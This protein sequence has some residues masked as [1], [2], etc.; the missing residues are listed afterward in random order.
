M[1]KNIILATATITL[2]YSCSVY[3]PVPCSFNFE[4]IEYFDDI[5]RYDKVFENWETILFIFD[6]NSCFSFSSYCSYSINITFDILDAILNRLNK[7][8]FDIKIIIHNHFLV[9]SFSYADLWF[10]KRLWLRGFTGSFQLYF[11]STS[12]IVEII[13]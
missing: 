6:D 4:A 9:K 3:K 7:S 2:L 11:T 8:I 12:E 13:E 5:P 10:S 1:N